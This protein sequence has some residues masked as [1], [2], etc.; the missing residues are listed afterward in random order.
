MTKG[1][2]SGGSWLSSRRRECPQNKDSMEQGKDAKRI[3]IHRLCMRF[4]HRDQ[5]L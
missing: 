4:N 1:F 2:R 3:I 5:V